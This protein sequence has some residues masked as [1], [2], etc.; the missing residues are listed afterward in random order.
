M[1]GQVRRTRWGVLLLC[2]VILLAVMKFIVMSQPRVSI[3]LF[4]GQQ[5]A[6]LQLADG[7]TVTIQIAYN[8]FEIFG[9]MGERRLLY[10]PGGAASCSSF[11]LGSVWED[12][13]TQSVSIYRR[14]DGA[15]VATD[16]MFMVEM[17]GPELRAL[18]YYEVQAALRPD[19]T[20]HVFNIA[21]NLLQQDFT[22][23][24]PNQKWAGDITYVWT[25]EG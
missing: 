15:T 18:S 24:G 4:G 6:S 1:G 11:W 14:A 17:V 23:S 8:E 5:S 3:L 16:H 25:R 7:A 21:P 19:A 22:A 9:G 20:E 12:R 2:C 10:C 13:Y